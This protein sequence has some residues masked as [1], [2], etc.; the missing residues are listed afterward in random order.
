MK[1][2]KNKVFFGGRWVS[3][4]CNPKRTF[5]RL[6][7][8]LYR[9]CSDKKY[10]EIALRFDLGY[11]V[12]LDNPKTFNEKLNWLK[13]Y[14]HNPLYHTLVDKLEV[15]EHVSKIIEEVHVA[16]VI[17]SWSN[18]DEI[19]FS[20][21]PRRFVL[22]QSNYGAPLVVKDKSELDIEA[23]RRKFEDDF[24]FDIFAATKEWPYKGLT[25]KIFAEEFLDNHSCN[26]VLQDYKFWCF[27][28]EPKVMY[29]TVK[30]NEVY[31]N[32]YDMDFNVV[33]I[34]HGFARRQPEFEKPVNFEEMKS[35]AAKLSEG[36]PFV[37][38]DFYNV[39]NKIYFGEYTF[40][41]WGG[42]HRFITKEQDQ[43]IGSWLDL[44]KI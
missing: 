15:K 20:K 4:I 5:Q 2:K 44:S 36:I 29:F 10:L 35:Y 28:G 8:R 41:D 38:M 37:R 42:T 6:V 32:F 31:E 14:N 30:D 9:G 12:D 3:A 34:N 21:L 33:D 1:T 16:K 23:A 25:P 27:N 40:F 11:K 19:D 13:I 26:N 17:Q 18:F 24:K 39:N 7:K 43:M 22:K